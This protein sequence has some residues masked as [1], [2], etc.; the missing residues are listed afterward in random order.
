MFC[1]FRS[2]LGPQLGHDLIFIFEPTLAQFCR[3]SSLM[4][5]IDDVI[6]NYIHTFIHSLS[7]LLIFLLAAPVSF[8]GVDQPCIEKVFAGVRWQMGP[9]LLLS[10][11]C[12]T[13]PHMTDY[14]IYA[15]LTRS[16]SEQFTLLLAFILGRACVCVCVW[17]VWYGCVDMCACVHVHVCVCV[18]KRERERERERGG[19]FGKCVCGSGSVC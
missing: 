7:L 12:H 13:L 2:M 19:Q 17:A 11:L 10:Q 18:C 16:D 14:L 15:H 9:R 6:F 5:M 1:V 8:P 3:S 4:M